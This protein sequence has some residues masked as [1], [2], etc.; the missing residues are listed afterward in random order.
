[1]ALRRV[2]S[3]VAL[4]AISLSLVLGSSGLARAQTDTGQHVYKHH[5]SQYHAYQHQ[6][7][8]GSRHAASTR[9]G[10]PNAPK[11]NATAHDGSWSVS[12]YASCEGRASPSLG[13]TVHVRNGNISYSGGD[14]SVSGR[15]SPNGATFAHVSSGDRQA[16]ASGHL[17]TSSGGGAFRG[18]AAGSPCTGTWRAVRI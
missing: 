7:R 2:L 12:I 6:G 16:N 1:M 5:A 13:F 10:A 4:P 11:G 18:Q 9:K 15:V 8:K 3:T 17:S 14:A